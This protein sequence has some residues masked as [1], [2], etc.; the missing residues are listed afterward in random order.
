MP[1]GASPIGAGPIGHTH[2][3]TTTTRRRWLA[4]LAALLLAAGCGGGSDPT[5]AY[6][7]LVNASPGYSSLALGVGDAAVA[8]SVAYG[9]SAGYVDVDP[10]SGKAAD[11]TT[12]S[13]AAVLASTTVSL[14]KKR[15]YSL[16]AY[17]KAGA[18]SAL[19]LDDNNATPDSGKTLVRVINT[20]PDAGSLDV[21][22]TDAGDL[23]SQSTAV[24]TQQAF[25]TLGGY[26]TI[27][28][29]AWRLRVTG[30]GVKTDLRLDVS[31]VN[32]PSQGVMTLVLTPGRGG[33][34]VNA[35]LLAQ[36][37]GITNAANTQAR[38]RAVAGVGGAAA[39]S[40]SVAGSAL[41]TNASVPSLTGYTLVPAGDAAVSAASDGA[42]TALS[43]ATL[44][45]GGDYT[46]LVYGAAGA[47][48]AAM[49]EDDNTLPGDSTMAKLRLVHGVGDVAAA[50]TLKVDSL[51]V[52][53]SVALGSAS[54]YALVA[55]ST[56]AQVSVTAAGSALPLYGSSSDQS[57]AAGANYTIF[58][59]G[60]SASPSIV[61]AKDR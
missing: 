11:V 27:V 16:L 2:M 23:L 43:S 1:A 33:V 15:Y 22:L 21:Y 34:L 31:G 28:S 53:D 18:L 10:V 14:S 60:S 55:N 50:L 20:A 51:V 52:A 17:G 9:A 54:P 26:S 8:S 24:F 45:A 32:F 29:K 3:A 4:S 35:L 7:R 37:S 61:K 6:L 44:A 13:S 41:L 30:A 46:L 38:V 25:G 58:A 56:T 5:K 40:A 59:V 42:S 12:P 39:V 57:F 48:V 19:L 49:I 47:P 36:Q